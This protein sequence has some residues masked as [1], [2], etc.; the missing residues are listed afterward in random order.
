MTL[1]DL[2]VVVFLIDTFS[3]L[4][5]FAVCTTVLFYARGVS[6]AMSDG[7]ET[8]TEKSLFSFDDV[9]GDGADC[10]QAGSVLKVLSST[11]EPK[12]ASVF[13]ELQGLDELF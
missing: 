11:G 13:S 10:L 7:G 1:D 12:R 6:Q 8:I 3:Y 9:Y 5:S 2:C 4:F